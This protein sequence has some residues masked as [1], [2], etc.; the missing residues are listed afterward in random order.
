MGV[1][2]RQLDEQAERPLWDQVINFEQLFAALHL[3]SWF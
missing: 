2:S 1:P 3:K